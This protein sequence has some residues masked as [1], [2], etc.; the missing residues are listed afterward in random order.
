MTFVNDPM[1]QS[2]RL[3]LVGRFGAAQG[4]RGEIRIRSYTADPASVGEYGPL[5]DETGARKFEIEK[6]RPL[7]DDMLVAKVKGLADR[8]AA[9]ALTGLALYVSREKLPA[10]DEDEFYVA[11]LIDLLAISPD[12]D[13][14]GHVKN[15]VN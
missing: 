11:D 5:C 3:V 14:I 7:K 10:P 13:L 6:L 15:V 1:P 12:G 8:D 4:V 9:A 2:P